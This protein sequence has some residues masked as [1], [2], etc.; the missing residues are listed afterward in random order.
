MRLDVTNQHR[1]C[2][3]QRGGRELVMWYC[4]MSLVKSDDRSSIVVMNRTE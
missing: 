2:L 4:K 3:V 1:R